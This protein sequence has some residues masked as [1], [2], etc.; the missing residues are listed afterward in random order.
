MYIPRFV[1]TRRISRR[2]P[3]LRR[4]G[5][6]TCTLN[7]WEFRAII[8][9]RGRTCSLSLRLASLHCI[10]RSSARVYVQVLPLQT[11]HR[12]RY[13]LRG[14]RSRRTGKQFPSHEKSKYHQYRVSS[15]P[16]RIYAVHALEIKSNLQLSRRRRIEPGIERIDPPS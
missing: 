6:N 13:R 1:H 11:V 7:N 14:S 16:F 12:S 15:V 2:R 4:S 3:K 8:E 10:A 5:V 9:C